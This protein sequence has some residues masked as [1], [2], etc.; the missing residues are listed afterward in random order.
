MNKLFS[1]ILVLLM[2]IP[3]YLFS[4]D[5]EGI[6]PFGR[7]IGSVYNRPVFSRGASF[8]ADWSLSFRNRY[9]L[10]YSSDDSSMVWHVDTL[11]FN[12]DYIK[13]GQGFWANCP[14][15]ISDPSGSF[16]YFE[17]FIGIPFVVTTNAWE[18]WK[19]TGDASYVIASAAGNLG[20]IVSVTPVT[21]SNNEI[22]FQLGE[23]GTETFIE[24][25][26]DSGL[27][28]WVEFRISTDAVTDAGIIFV[29]LA[30]EG[31]SAA[32]FLNDD[33]A[34]VAD[35]DV[36][37]FCVFEA[38][39]DTVTFIYQTSGSAFVTDTLSVITTAYFTAG[40]HFDG[41]TTVDIYINGTQ[42]STVETDVA[43]FPDGEELS[44]I[45]AVKNGA[46]DKTVYLDWIKFVNER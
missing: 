9:N 25:T 41:V 37:G 36:V 18:G 13:Q 14:L 1:F 31:S 20:G 22:Y 28:S 12:I 16:R 45:V 33:G 35:K 7:N 21:A 43:G 24:Y 42:V 11:T 29:G 38:N 46:A 32:D 4:Q 34:D 44:P 15:P 10:M 5:G 39:P 40:L 17:D 26:G 2:V 23:L 19:A 6:G 3:L 27:Q 30:E 8:Y